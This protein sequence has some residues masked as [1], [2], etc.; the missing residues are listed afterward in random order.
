LTGLS[1][2]EIYCMRLK[3]LIPSGIVGGRVATCSF[4]RFDDTRDD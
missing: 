4:R 3:R 2:N 1:G